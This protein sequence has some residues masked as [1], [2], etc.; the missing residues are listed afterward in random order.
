MHNQVFSLVILL[1]WLCKWCF[2]KW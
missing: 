1:S 2:R